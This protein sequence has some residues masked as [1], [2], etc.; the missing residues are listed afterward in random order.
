MT[1]QRTICL[2][3]RPEDWAWMIRDIFHRVSK[4]HP[5]ASHDDS[6]EN[7]NE[8]G[9]IIRGEIAAEMPDDIE[10]I[11]THNQ[12]V[13]VGELVQWSRGEVMQDFVRT[14]KRVSREWVD[15]FATEVERDF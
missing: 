15:A 8:L 7:L 9:N 1:E 12:R 10:V 5:E 2:S 13:G 14:C 11:W 3:A 6:A 4:I